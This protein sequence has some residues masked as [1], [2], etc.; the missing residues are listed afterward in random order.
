MQREQ[1]IAVIVAVALFMEQVDATIIATALPAIAADLGTTPLKLNVAVTAYLLALAIFIP[2]SG[3]FADRFGA[4]NVF[5]GAIV[6]FMV[7]SVLCALSTSLPAFVASRILQ[8]MGGAMMTPVARLII[9]RTVDKQQLLKAMAFMS[10][11]G[12]AGPLFGPPLGGLIVTIATWHWI[13]IVNIPIGLLGI[14][15][16]TKY[17]PDVSVAKAARFD[18]VGMLLIGFGLGGLAF[19]LSMTRN[20]AVP[21]L[22][23]LALA[24]AGAVLIALY[25]AH[26]RRIANPVLDIGL[27]GLRSIQVSVFGGFL[28]RASLGAM[29]F[30]LPLMFQLGFGMSP[31][32][33]GFLVISTSVGV[34]L[35][36]PF[37]PALLR[38]LGFRNLLLLNGPLVSLTFAMFALLTPETAL[39]VIVPFLIFN[40]FI[41]SMQFT[42]Y[43]AITFADVSPAKMSHATSLLAVSSQ[44]SIS[45]GVA[46]GALAVELAM[47]WHGHTTPTATDFGPAFIAIAL[48][49]AMSFFV[50]L[51]LPADAGAEIANRAPT[52]VAP[53]EDQTK[54]QDPPQRKVG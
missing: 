10:I 47:Q 29:P 25:V 27:L 17:I 36:K 46:I 13:F 16:V 22:V 24:A 41:R 23:D 4:R 34:L 14:V 6:V 18:L 35:V 28:F 44:L 50:S 11:P 20:A 19:G 9:V 38:I 33:S 40:G 21:L 7:G 49:T 15:M 5:R 32:Q 31:L 26:A 48:V 3:W 43:S 12:L 45:T 1:L 2:V 8:G 42:T 53:P 30:L 54:P 39:W 37:A 51:R 52:P